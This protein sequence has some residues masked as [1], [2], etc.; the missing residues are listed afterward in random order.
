MLI[1]NYINR[2]NRNLHDI[3]IVILLHNGL[4]NLSKYI[5]AEFPLNFVLIMNL[6][7]DTVPNQKTP[8]GQSY[9]KRENI[10]CKYCDYVAQ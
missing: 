10:K 1:Y 6:D 2:F 5:Q 9:L 7:N 8:N 3:N 4:K